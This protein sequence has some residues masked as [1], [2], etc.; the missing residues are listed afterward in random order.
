MI[1]FFCR[2][3]HAYP[4]VVNTLDFVDRQARDEYSFLWMFFEIILCA[5]VFSKKITDFFVV[6]FQKRRMHEIFYAI[7]GW[8]SL[9]DMFEGSK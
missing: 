9:E 1:A 6:N 5:L 3:R 4:T 7:I 2:I 8:G